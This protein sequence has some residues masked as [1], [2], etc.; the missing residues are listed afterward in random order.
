[1]SLKTQYN[2][3]NLI[4]KKNTTTKPNIP[5]D[6]V[7]I[8][9][10]PDNRM[11]NTEIIILLIPYHF[12]I[13]F[14]TFRYHFQKIWK[15]KVDFGFHLFSFLFLFH[16]ILMLF[17]VID[18]FVGVKRVIWPP[19]SSS[20]STSITRQSPALQ[21]QVSHSND[22]PTQKCVRFFLFYLFWLRDFSTFRIISINIYMA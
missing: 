14:I 16:F 18:L 3:V 7:M 12:I 4:W 1:M 5:T 6:Q 11:T 9:G 13:Y 15:S 8:C 21:S 2:A 22:T 20:R 19:E 17:I 10:C